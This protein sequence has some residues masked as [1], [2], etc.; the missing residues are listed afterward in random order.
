MKAK[1]LP[2]PKTIQNYKWR[3]KIRK[4][5]GRPLMSFE[6]YCPK[7][8][9]W[10]AFVRWDGK[11]TWMRN[12]IYVWGMMARWELL[13]PG[14]SFAQFTYEWRD[15]PL[16]RKEW[17]KWNG[18]P[19]SYL[20]WWLKVEEAEVEKAKQLFPEKKWV[21]KAWWE[22]KTGHETKQLMACIE[23]PKEAELLWKAGQPRLAQSKSIWKLKKTRMKALAKIVATERDLSPGEA[24][25]MLSHGVSRKMAQ[26]MIQLRTNNVREVEY[27]EEHGEYRYQRYKE[28]AKEL[29]VNMA[30]DYWR[31]PKDFERKYEELEREIMKRLATAERARM[32]KEKA[33]RKREAKELA[34]REKLQKAQ[35]DARKNMHEVKGWGM[36]AWV[37]ETEEEIRNQAE[38]L[39]QCL[40]RCEYDRRH[41][42][43]KLLL[44]F[45]RDEK[46]KPVATFELDE[47][48]RVKQATKSQETKDWKVTPQMM[49]LMR[50]W[51]R[52]NLEK[53]A[54]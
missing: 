16:D 15:V 32:R 27:M 14:G 42:E 30:D 7:K 17:D 19:P 35:M 46:G 47:R 41:F 24:Q 38:T 11:D 49:K 31:F 37:P 3:M 26:K 21:I 4:R 18:V 52:E 9:K 50:K 45:M 29:A 13:E 8:R 48:G 25:R 44:V 39:K 53:I 23:G 34:K 1:R 10:A 28:M 2:P 6:A 36:V 20:T 40:L 54:Q 22:A 51:R 5:A 43:G 33:R 12:I